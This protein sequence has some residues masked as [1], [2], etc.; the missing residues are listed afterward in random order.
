MTTNI[1]V[2]DDELEFMTSGIDENKVTF[3]YVAN[4]KVFEQKIK[5]NQDYRF[6]IKKIKDA[7]RTDYRPKV[8]LVQYS[9]DTEKGDITTFKQERYS[10]E[11]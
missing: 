4:Q 5:N 9:N 6:S 11:K 8:Q 2:K 3:I 1:A 7:H 10:V